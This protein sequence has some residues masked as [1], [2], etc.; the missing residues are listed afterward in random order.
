MTK[1]DTNVSVEEICKMEILVS[2]DCCGEY[3]ND[4]QTSH[5]ICPR[6]LE[7]CDI[8]VEKFILPS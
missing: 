4:F 1:F 2:S 5:G 6:C 3:L 7:H 8:V